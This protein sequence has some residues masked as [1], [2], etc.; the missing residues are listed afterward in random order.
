MI[1]FEGLLA[2]IVAA[3]GALAMAPASSPRIT[4]RIHRSFITTSSIRFR[5]FPQYRNVCAGAVQGKGG[6]SP[7]APAHPVHFGMPLGFPVTGQ[8]VHAWARRG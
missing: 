8:M 7:T 5:N 6:N 2:L 3:S 4:A 1:S